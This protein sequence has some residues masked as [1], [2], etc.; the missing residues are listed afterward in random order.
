[1]EI[2]C[3][4]VKIEVADAS[5]NKNAKKLSESEMPYDEGTYTTLKRE[6]VR[7]Q[8]L[9]APVDVL[10][11]PIFPP[12]SRLQPRPTL[13]PL[14]GHS[15]ERLDD[16]G[17]ILHQIQSSQDIVDSVS[18]K[19]PTRRYTLVR[20]A[21]GIYEEIPDDLVGEDVYEDV[22]ES[23]YMHPLSQSDRNHESPD[24]GHKS[25]DPPGSPRL[26]RKRESYVTKL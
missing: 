18:G 25:P 20:T 24:G 15:I 7:P 9:K 19:A 12:H 17:Y 2:C 16:C 1:M 8:V 5:G 6:L 3:Y 22:Y 23:G 14:P 26:N 13:P 11:P 10:G 21:S 4:S